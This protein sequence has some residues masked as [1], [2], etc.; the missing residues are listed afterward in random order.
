MNQKKAKKLR[1]E[2]YG[3]DDP[4]ADA[5]RYGNDPSEFKRFRL[6]RKNGKPT[7]AIK[8]ETTK[9]LIADP[10]RRYY[11]QLKKNQ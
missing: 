7:G 5:R 10:S 1:R 2:A 3:K 6:V 8:T 4:G 9:P 11:R